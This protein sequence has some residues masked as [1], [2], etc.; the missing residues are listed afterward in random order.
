[1]SEFE[2]SDRKPTKKT[3]TASRHPAKVV[4]RPPRAPKVGEDGFGSG[5]VYEQRK[6]LWDER[7]NPER[8]KS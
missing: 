3:H 2:T 5:H 4:N 8:D 7:D 6:K 1:M